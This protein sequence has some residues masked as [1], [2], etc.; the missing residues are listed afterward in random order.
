MLKTV[1][2][3]LYFSFIDDQHRFLSGADFGLTYLRGWT[4]ITVKVFRSRNLLLVL[5]EQ[6]LILNSEIL[7]LV[8]DKHLRQASIIE[9]TNS[10]VAHLQFF[11]VVSGAIL[12]NTD[13]LCHFIFSLLRQCIS[14]SF[15]EQWVVGRPLRGRSAVPPVSVKHFIALINPHWFDTSGV[16]TLTRT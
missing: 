6:L 7:I 11:F 4:M 16:K 14:A 10:S 5:V 2:I 15:S 8:G 13:L 3:D 9:Q 1:F 12:A